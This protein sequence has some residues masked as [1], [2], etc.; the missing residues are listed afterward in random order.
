MAPSA[1]LQLFPTLPTK[2]PS[3]NPSLPHDAIQ[4]QF[5]PS[6]ALNRR[7]PDAEPSNYV[8]GNRSP[9]QTSNAQIASDIPR[10]QTSFTEAPTLIRNNSD[11]SHS[12]IQK[13]PRSK[14][15]SSIRGEPVSRSIF[16]RYDHN[17]PLDQ[18]AY[19]P[20]QTTPTHIPQTAIDRRTTYDL[21]YDT[22]TMPGE[23]PT[24]SPI[25]GRSRV[26]RPSQAAQRMMPFPE[27]SSTEELKHLWKVTNGWR[28]QSSEGRS[29]HL[30]MTR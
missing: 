28:V 14:K 11:T 27:P 8:L 13:P 2:G 21:T 26:E 9:S 25:S 30:K 16:P 18:Q 10:S 29:F 23:A 3:R 12:S 5:P 15:F 6:A 4:A 19:Y 20:Q 7:F 1:G 22:T 24:T 17:K